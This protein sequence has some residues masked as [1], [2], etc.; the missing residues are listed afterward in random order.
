MSVPSNADVNCSSGDGD[1]LDYAEASGHVGGETR[2][3]FPTTPRPKPKPKPPPHPPPGLRRR[4]A[5]RRR[6]GSLGQVMAGQR[7]EEVMLESSPTFVPT[8]GRNAAASR[9]RERGDVSKVPTAWGHGGDTSADHNL[10]WCE[11]APASHASPISDFDNGASVIV[12]VGPGVDLQCLVMRRRRRR[13]RRR[14]GDSPF[15]D[16]AAATSQCLRER[17]SGGPTVSVGHATLRFGPIN[18]MCVKRLSSAATRAE[19]ARMQG[20]VSDL[21]K[22]AGTPP[23][24]LRAPPLPGAAGLGPQ[25]IYIGNNLL[26]ATH[27]VASWRGATKC[28]VGGAL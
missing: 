23:R 3:P 11:T 27:Q 12:G 21:L 1:L 6:E 14:N 5:V 24:C 13:R 7:D 28:L 17:D 15:R 10:R 20:G 25:P 16:Q 19:P 8:E 26:H 2:A 4:D 22:E 9:V 18:T